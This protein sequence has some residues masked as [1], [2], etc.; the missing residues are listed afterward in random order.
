M[1]TN[2]LNPHILTWSRVALSYWIFQMTA[3]NRRVWDSV[4][5][6]IWHYQFQISII[7]TKFNFFQHGSYRSLNYSVHY[8]LWWF[9]LRNIHGSVFL[10]IFSGVYVYSP[11]PSVRR[12][13][14]SWLKNIVTWG[15]S[16]NNLNYSASIHLEFNSSTWKK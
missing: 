4:F 12:L 1:Y 14:I 15:A 9:L 16:S 13:S 5:L 10:Q 11:P 2:V 8:F 7:F 3:T 6:Q